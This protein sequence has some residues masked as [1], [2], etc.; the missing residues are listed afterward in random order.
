MVVG[1]LST[2]R[3]VAHALPAR[4][5]VATRHPPSRPAWHRAAAAPPPPPLPLQLQ[6]GLH[7]A[8]LD[9]A[10]HAAVVPHGLAVEQV[11]QRGFEVVLDVFVVGGCRGGGG[12]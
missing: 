12:R 8:G 3:N 2:P 9:P 6:L 11:R 1:G 5:I 4:R 10:A 7:Q